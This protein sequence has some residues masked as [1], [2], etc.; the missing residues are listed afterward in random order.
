MDSGREGL[1]LAALLRLGLGA[2]LSASHEAPPGVPLLEALVGARRLR[3]GQAVAVRDY[4]YRHRAECACGHVTL[5]PD[6][7][8][9][10][11]CA[12]CGVALARSASGIYERSAAA[13]PERPFE[14]GSR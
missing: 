4:V 13:P 10:F 2:A 1:E 8:V 12:H 14:L 7:A 5:A 11:A 3:Q 9:P 6:E